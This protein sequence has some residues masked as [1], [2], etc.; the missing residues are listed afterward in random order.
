MPRGSRLK[1]ELGL[2]RGRSGTVHSAAPMRRAFTI[3]E[4][5]LTLLVLTLVATFSIT[6]YFSRPEVT[7]THA[8][9]ILVGDLRLAQSRAIEL[10]TTF[11][12][13][14]ENGGD[15]YH[16]NLIGVAPTDV[17][18]RHYPADA[19]FEGVFISRVVPGDLKRI[20]FDENGEPSSDAT[21]VL[22]FRGEARGVRI[23]RASGAISVLEI[24]D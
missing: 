20:L 3:L 12:F 24:D 6:A 11:E 13:A 14:L 19:I 2:A 4:L 15:G 22:S 21:I 23:D 8:T 7:L 17:A 1:R 16:Y 18:T 9:E 10:H 5:C